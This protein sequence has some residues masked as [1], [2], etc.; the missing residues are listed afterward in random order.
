V[1]DHFINSGPLA[2]IHA[3]MKAASNEAVF[4]FAGD[5]PF[6]DREIIIKQIQLYN[7]I[8]CDLLIPRI[9]DN[10]EPLHSIYNTSIENVLKEY[11]ELDSDRAVRAFFKLLS[12]KFFLLE[13]SK[14]N[15]TAFFNI[16]SPTDISSIQ[17]NIDK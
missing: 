2:G 5:M 11:L 16:N 17:K 15:I 4:V 13:S 12:V 6:L 3:A 1:G 14:K 10:I 9:G 7:E 8:K